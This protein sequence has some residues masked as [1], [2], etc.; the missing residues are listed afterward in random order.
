LE[1]ERQGLMTQ[2][3]AA[4]DVLQILQRTRIY[5]L[6]RLL[7]RWRFMEQTVLQL[8]AIQASGI[9][10]SDALPTKKTFGRT[11]LRVVACLLHSTKRLTQAGITCLVTWLRHWPLWS[12]IHFTDTETIIEQ[13][14]H[15]Y[16]TNKYYTKHYYNSLTQTHKDH[17]LFDVYL[18][19]ELG[20]LNRSRLI[21]ESLCTTLKKD[22][23]FHEKRCLD[24]GCSSGNS[25]IAL[26]EFGSAEAIGLEVSRNRLK[27]ALINI[28]GCSRIQRKRIRTFHG[29]VLD[30]GLISKLGLFDVIFCLD[31]LEH[32]DSPEL[33]IKNIK[34]LLKNDEESFAFIQLCNR[35]HYENI[36]H[37]PHYN[38]PGLILLDPSQALEYYIAC[39]QDNQEDYEVKKWLTLDEF[40]E[41]CE[42][43]A[44]SYEYYVS[45]DCQDH[46]V[47]MI[48][49][50]LLQVKERLE[51]YLSNKE[52]E[53]SLRSLICQVVDDYIESVV[54][55]IAKYRISKNPE[56]LF[57]LCLKYSVR[58]YNFI[59]RSRR[60]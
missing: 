60:N 33:T 56:Q 32:V 52:I 28:K 13:L 57:R 23:F 14:V 6:L 26:T 31:V 29:S 55:E 35:F 24:I 20:T 7:G 45:V 36:M 21:F 9:D 8:S 42:K 58:S 17:P 10:S 38:I 40:E 5:R 41:L 37:E 49:T 11:A 39:R 47:D 25:L 15:K 1:T 12:W 53:H 2:L 51:S 59:L 54:K 4:Q 43:N 19:S 44:L 34:E 46:T 48:E 16:G 22:D 18:E 50:N 27:T 3:L 30:K